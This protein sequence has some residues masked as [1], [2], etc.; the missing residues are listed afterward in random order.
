MVCGHWEIHNPQESVGYEKQY[1][2][3]EG[4]RVIHLILRVHRSVVQEESGNLAK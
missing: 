2:A 4:D 1:L 3:H